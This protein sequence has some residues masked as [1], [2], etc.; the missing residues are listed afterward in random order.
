MTSV[1]LPRFKD[2]HI[3]PLKFHNCSLDMDLNSAISKE[4]RRLQIAVSEWCAKATP[5]MQH[6]CKK[7]KYFVDRLHGLLENDLYSVLPQ[8]RRGS[9]VTHPRRGFGTL[10]ISAV[11]GLITLAVESLGSYLRNKQEKWINDAVLAM[12]E[13]NTAVQNMLQ[14][15]SN[16]FLMYGRY[17]VET[18]EKV[19]QTVNSLHHRQTQLE[20]VFAKTQ[21][22]HVDEIIDAISFNFDLHLYMKLIE[23]EHISQYQ[24]LEKAS[25]DLLKGIETLGQGKLPRELVSDTRLRTMLKEV[26]SMIRKQFPDYKLADT[27]IL[28]YRDMKLVT[29]SIDRETHSLVISFPV[30]VKDFCQPPLKLYEVDTV[31]VPIPDRNNKV[32]SY[33]KVRIHKPYLAAGDDYYIQL[34]MTELVMCKSIRHTYYCEELL[35]VKHK[36]RQSCASAIFYDLGPE[37][38]VQKCQFDYIYNTTMPP[39]VLDGGRSLLLANFHGPRSLKCNSKNGGLPKPAPEHVYAVVDRSFLCDCQL[40][41][42]HHATILRQLSSCT[43]NRTAHF[44]VEFVVNL[45]FYQLLQNR[46]PNLVENICPNAK[47]RTQVF[48]V[49]LAPVAQTPLEE[50]TDLK[51]ALKHIGQHGHLRSAL[52]NPDARPPPVLTRHTGHVLSIVVTVLSVGLFILGGLFLLRHFKLWTLVAGLTLASAPRVVNARQQPTMTVKCSNPYLTILATM[53]TII[54]TS[55]WICTHCQHLTWLHGYK[56]SRACTLYIFLYNSHFYV[57]LKIRRLTGH[58]HMYRIENPIAPEK[59]SFHRHCLWDSYVVNWGSMKLYVNGVPVQMPLSLTVPLRDKIK[60]RRMMTKDDLDLQFMI[61][62]GANWYNLTDKRTSPMLT[63]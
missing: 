45:G 53:V 58:M 19:I 42:E 47:G 63:A 49:Q 39:T 8:L 14:Q 57:P 41:L 31:V 51:N 40:D 9:Q 55:M 46:H 2:I 60:T 34:K 7:E 28:H 18:L 25:H 17:N 56:Y 26:R 16:D 62:Q 54:A 5:Y 3:S 43:D 10:V 24:L 13:D 27:S 37:E 4:H 59:L 11:T 50:P 36:S 22:G 21:S 15:Y 52:G 35:V 20:E 44:R 1:P 29:F 30:F 38:V 12:R 61:K 48:N 23:E 32:D 33:T 6:L